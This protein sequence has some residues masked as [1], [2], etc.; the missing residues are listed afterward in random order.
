MTD[1]QI[2]SGIDFIHEP[3]CGRGGFKIHCH[4]WVMYDENMILS[5]LS[6]EYVNP[7]GPFRKWVSL[8]CE[9]ITENGIYRFA[10]NTDFWKSCSE[11]EFVE[12]YLEPFLELLRKVVTGQMGVADFREIIPGCS[13]SMEHLSEDEKKYFPEW[14]DRINNNKMY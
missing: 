3:G 9:V 6:G 5:K 14:I 12:R 8:F 4:S 1:E 10:Y 7:V 2:I 11:Q 13:A